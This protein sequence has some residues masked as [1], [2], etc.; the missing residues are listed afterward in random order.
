MI[1]YLSADFMWLVDTRVEEHY[2]PAT[3]TQAGRCNAVLS[4]FPYRVLLLRL[5]AAVRA[6]R[7]NPLVDDASLRSK[8]DR[9]GRHRQCSVEPADDIFWHSPQH[10]ERARWSVPVA[11]DRFTGGERRFDVGVNMPIPIGS[12][13]ARK[14]VTVGSVD[15]VPYVVTERGTRWLLRSVNTVPGDGEEVA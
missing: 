3:T 1:Y 9:E 6:T 15:S 14:W 5:P 7:R 10:V 2:W 13:K 11:N 12:E 4:D 8:D